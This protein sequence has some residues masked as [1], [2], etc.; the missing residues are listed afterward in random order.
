MIT[1]DYITRMIQVLAQ[2]LAK[3]L[4][5]KESHQ[6]PEALRE[7][8]ET[9]LKLLGLNLSLVERLPDDQI[10]RLFG[11]DES[12]SIPKC[13]A[14]AKLLKEKGH[15]QELMGDEEGSFQEY[16]KSA[17]LFVEAALASERSAAADYE[18]DA[19]FVIEKL[20]EYEIPLETEAKIF[21]YYEHTGRFDRAE[22][23]LIDLIDRDPSFADKGIAFYERLLALSE[24]ELLRG[25]LPRGEV[26]EALAE[27]VR[28]KEMPPSV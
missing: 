4:G 7:I 2:A 20:S 16:L 17:G 28:K 13:Y 11:S 9:G 6:Y 27:L 22:D 18:A 1:R 3:V 21:G 10:M 23:A 26:E 15:I 5:L 19:D 24:E 14:I 12:L 25:G 8:D